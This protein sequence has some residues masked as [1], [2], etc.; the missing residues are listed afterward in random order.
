[1]TAANTALA[2]STPELGSLVGLSKSCSRK[3]HVTLGQEQKLRREEAQA[4]IMVPREACPEC[5]SLRMSHRVVFGTLEAV[6]PVLATPRLANQHEFCGAA[7]S[8]HPSACGC[9]GSSGHYVMQGRGRLA[10][11]ARVVPRG[12]QFLLASYL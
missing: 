6:K 9:R 4:S 5:G 10:A 3:V 7:Q 2:A 12:L 11:P 8:R 1:M